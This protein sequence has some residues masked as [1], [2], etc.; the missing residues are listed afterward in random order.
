MP[1]VCR[2]RSG[3]GDGQTAEQIGLTSAS[4]GSSVGMSVA[5][6]SGAMAASTAAIAIPIVGGVIAAVGLFFAWKSKQG[7]QKVAST[8]IVNEIEPQFKANC[9][10][11][12]NASVRT[13]AM[14]AQALANFD[15]GWKILSSS[16]GCGA[17]SLGGAGEA[18]IKDRNRGGKWDWFA[19]YRDPIANTPPN[20]SGAVAG[21]EGAVS[22]LFGGFDLFPF[23]IIGGL[24]MVA[25]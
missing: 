15:A 3:L 9:D 23:L 25:L 17:S 1:Y 24:L 6:S 10:A 18:C 16:Q 14:Q 19:Y 2:A 22:N 8:N 4:V 12:V 7:A 13:A 21:A 5:V 11:Y 20:D